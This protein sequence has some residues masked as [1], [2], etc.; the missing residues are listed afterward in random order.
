MRDI[1]GGGFS[2]ITGDQTLSFDHDQG[3]ATNLTT[4]N[5]WDAP[6]TTDVCTYKIQIRTTNSSSTVTIQNG[7]RVSYLIAEEKV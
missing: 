6:A 7:G 5:F 2:D 3:G 4:L 1:N